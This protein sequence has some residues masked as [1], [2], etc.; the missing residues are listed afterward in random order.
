MA[1]PHC[2][3]GRRGAD[4][5]RCPLPATAELASGRGLWLLD[6]Y[7][8]GYRVGVRRRTRRRTDQAEEVEPLSHG[9]EVLDELR[10]PQRSL[11]EAI[12]ETWPGFAQ[13]VSYTHLTLPTKRI[14]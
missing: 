11:R 8:P 9:R 14:V 4:V 12:P 10:G 5:L 1:A 7:P 6:L 2:G 3:S 13:P